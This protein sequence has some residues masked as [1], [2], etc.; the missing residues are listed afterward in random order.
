MLLGSLP[1]SWN[2]LVMSLENSA[3]D[4]KVTFAMVRNRLLKGRTLWAMTHMPLS[5]KTGVEVKVKDHLGITS[6]EVDPSP[7]EK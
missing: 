3:L 6:Q 2:T 1:D 5:R 4:G 7:E